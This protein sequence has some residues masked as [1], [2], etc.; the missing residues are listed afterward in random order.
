MSPH[1]SSLRD[2]N[3]MT[4][5]GQYHP[6][7]YQAPAFRVR[8]AGEDAGGKRPGSARTREVTRL[9]HLPYDRLDALLAGR[10]AL[11]TSFYRNACGFLAKHL[12]ALASDLNRRYF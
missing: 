11:A 10:P 9:L 8:G 6:Q 5:P 12:R 3:T 2:G 4:I 1:Y 7:G